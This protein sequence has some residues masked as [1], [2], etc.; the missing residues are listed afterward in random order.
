MENMQPFL[1]AK[2][3]TSETLKAA[4]MATRN[5]PES[6]QVNPVRAEALLRGYL[7]SWGAYA[8]MATDKMI[9][10]G[11][12]PAMRTDQLPVL[13]RFYAQE[14]P[15]RTKYET[16]FFDL[17][18]EANRLHGTLREL[19]R[20]GLSGYAD[21]K[22]KS[23]L[24]GEA[25]PLEH[26]AKNLSGI[27]KDMTAVRRDTSLTPEEKRTRLDALTAERNEL[28]KRTVQ[29]SKAAQRKEEVAR[30][31]TKLRERAK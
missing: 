12:A 19:D 4:G 8:L 7:N 11:N 20:Q 30:A 15:L 16:Q 31:E 21:E 26:A 3:G 10:G 22:E 18:N 13:R 17:L 24:A 27:N 5:L 2:P 29:E 6:L 1:R 25:K 23:P 14:P 28:L 9:A